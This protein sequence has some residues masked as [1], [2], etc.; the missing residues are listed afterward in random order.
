M[1]EA[2]TGLLSQII[3]INSV[4]LGEEQAVLTMNNRFNKKAPRF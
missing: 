2:L 4:D 3:Y 1:L